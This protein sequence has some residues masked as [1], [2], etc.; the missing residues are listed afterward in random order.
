MAIKNNKMII[1]KTKKH[2]S[3]KVTKRKQYGG[4][5]NNLTQILGY[6]HNLNVKQ[7]KPQERYELEYQIKKHKNYNA[8]ERKYREYIKKYPR[9]SKATTALQSLSRV[10]L[11]MVATVTA[12]RFAL[13]KIKNVANPYYRRYHTDSYYA[14]KRTNVKAALADSSNYIKSGQKARTKSL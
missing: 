4:S 9:L 14:K 7:L 12:P 2:F 8:K 3:Q 10:P 13:Q 1:K 5:G 6:N 11:S